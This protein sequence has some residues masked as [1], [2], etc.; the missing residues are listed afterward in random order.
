MDTVAEDTRFEVNWDPGRT[1]LWFHMGR[2]SC[3]FPGQNNILSISNLRGD[4][5]P[6]YSHRTNNGYQLGWWQVGVGGVKV[7]YGLVFNVARKRFKGCTNFG[8]LRHAAAQ[9]VKHKAVT[10]PIYEAC[11]PLICKCRLVGCLPLDYGTPEHLE[12][13]WLQ[14]AELQGFQ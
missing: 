1:S 14:V 3:R 2:G 4:V 10:W 11:Y 5:I 6:D 8:I 9:F 7:D 13:M 12:A